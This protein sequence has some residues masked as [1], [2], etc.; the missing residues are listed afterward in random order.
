MD[1]NLIKQQ[2]IVEKEGAFMPI[3]FLDLPASI[4]GGI[5]YTC[6]KQIGKQIDKKIE[7][8]PEKLR[9]SPAPSINYSANHLKALCNSIDD[10]EL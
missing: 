4:C 10:I 6:S 9:L 8:T 3:I 7:R 1:L 2:Q 5:A